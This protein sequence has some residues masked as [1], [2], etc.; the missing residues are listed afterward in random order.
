MEQKANFS[1]EDVKRIVQSDAAQQLMALLQKN[2]AQQLSDAMAQA[3][4]GNYE[5]VKKTLSSAMAS[6]EVQALLRQLGGG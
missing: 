2:N 4:A 3:S 1:Q 6:P 5:Q